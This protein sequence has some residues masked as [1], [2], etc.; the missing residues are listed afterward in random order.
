[1]R[2]IWDLVLSYLKSPDGKTGDEETVIAYASR[3]LHSPETRYATTHLEA[4]ALV[5]AVRHFR[6]YLAGRRFVLIIDHAGLQY[7]F[8]NPRPSN[9]MTR[10]VADL[11]EKRRDR[12]KYPSVH[13]LKTPSDKT[14]KPE[15][16]DRKNLPKCLQL[17]A[18][19]E[20]EKDLQTLHCTKR[21]AIQ[22]IRKERP[23]SRGPSLENIVGYVERVHNEG[24][25]RNW[26]ARVQSVTTAEFL[27]RQVKC[28]HGLPQYIL[29]DR[30]G[31][32]TSDYVHNFLRA[33]QVKHLTT[34]A[35][36][37]QTNGLCERMNGTIVSVLAKLVRVEKR[38]TDWDI[39]LDSALLAIRSMP[40]ESTGHTTAKLLYGYDIWTPAIWPS[41][42]RDYVEGEY[43]AAVLGR[44]H[45]IDGI[46]REFWKEARA[47]DE[48]RRQ[49]AAA[50]YNRTVIPRT[51]EVGDLML[52]R[53]HYPRHKLDNKWIDPL[54]VSRANNNGTY[55]LVGPFGRRIEEAVNGYHLKP[56][57]KRAAMRP[58]VQNS[59]EVRD[60]LQAFLERR[61]L[62]AE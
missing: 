42:S 11:M 51:F 4:L 20:S 5:W 29:T 32:F 43:D 46:M 2:P 27:Y 36:R 30:G 40:N 23:W 12:I 48:V 39:F 25:L 54:A 22:A 17:K 18:T 52:L 55:H 35:F 21:C 10:W 38:V 31:N 34:T 19:G 45:V 50:R 1:M 53:D 61:N 7:V 14:L 15:L 44:V 33:M 49:R 62:S 26:C 47:R 13:T 56:W 16:S 57:H 60:Q 58:E 28:Q 8:S 24:H 41:P 6:H 59:A 3:A 9:K 37:P